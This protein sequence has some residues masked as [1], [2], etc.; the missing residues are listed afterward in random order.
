MIRM[1]LKAEFKYRIRL[2]EE[3]GR[4]QF[5]AMVANHI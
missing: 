3:T 1:S 2:D 4:R 5:T